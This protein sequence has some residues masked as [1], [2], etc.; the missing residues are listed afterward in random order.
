MDDRQKKRMLKSDFFSTI[1]TI[2][3]LDQDLQNSTGTQKNEI[4]Q[5][6]PRFYGSSIHIRLKNSGQEKELLKNKKVSPW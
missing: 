5:G 6:S 1:Q 2:S 4:S 3:T